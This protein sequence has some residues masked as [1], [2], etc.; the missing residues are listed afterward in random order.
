MGGQI[1]GFDFC[2]DEINRAIQF[3]Q[4]NPKT[5]PL[6]P[7][8]ERM[9]TKQDCLGIL[10]KAGIEIQ[11]MYKMGYNNNNCIGCIKGGMGYW[12]KIRTDFPEKFKRISEIE[13][14][15]GATCLKDEDG[16]RIFL[17]E[18][19]PN[20]GNKMNPIIPDC[21]LSC[22]IEFAEIEDKN[23]KKILNGELSIN[24]I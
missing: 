18:L 9:L 3:K 14:R 12:N 16:N 15:V 6:F 20:R 24:D 1:W 13:R 10:F 2:K 5:K 7:L 21:S 19:D 4:Q 23:T 17:D 11:M 22:E 8:I